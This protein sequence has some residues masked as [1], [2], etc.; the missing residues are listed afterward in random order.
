[1]SRRRQTRIRTRIRT[2]PEPEPNP[3]PFPNPNPN[4]EGLRPTRVGAVSGLRV[5]QE[6]KVGYIPKRQ[7]ANYA[8]LVVLLLNHPGEMTKDQVKA[9]VDRAL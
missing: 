6:V 9:S 1:M 4:P 5:V 3:N 2:Q 8:V 7:S